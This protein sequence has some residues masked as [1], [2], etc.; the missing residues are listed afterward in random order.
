MKKIGSSNNIKT[1]CFN[2]ILNKQRQKLSLA[3]ICIPAIVIYMCQ[4]T[5]TQSHPRFN[6]FNEANINLIGNQ[7][8]KNLV[9]IVEKEIEK[10][11]VI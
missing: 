1:T 9:T 7:F 11:L 3:F 2:F 5:K 8:H 10:I 6:R 4:S